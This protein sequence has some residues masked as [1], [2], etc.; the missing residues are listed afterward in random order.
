MIS[1]SKYTG[2]EAVV[3]YDLSIPKKFLSG[4]GASEPPCGSSQQNHIPF[5]I[6]SVSA[7]LNTFIK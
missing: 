6:R 5:G 4:A 1:A 3:S 7:K 2:F